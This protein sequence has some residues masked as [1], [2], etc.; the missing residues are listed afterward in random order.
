MNMFT[1]RD[2]VEGSF[3][4]PYVAFRGGRMTSAESAVPKN[5]PAGGLI[6]LFTFHHLS[7]PP[8]SKNCD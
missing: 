7:R 1:L 4:P 2:L 3:S 5:S 8:Q 6:A